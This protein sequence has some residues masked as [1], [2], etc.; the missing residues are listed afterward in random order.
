MKP[1][2]L[3]FQ[4]SKPQSMKLMKAFMPLKLKIKNVHTEDI[5]T[6]IGT[7]AGIKDMKTL[8]STEESQELSDPMIVFAGLS[9]THL[10]LALAAVRKSGVGP[11]PYKAVLTPSNQSWTAHELLEELKIEHEKMHQS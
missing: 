8:D 4:F 11:V 2:I 3:L 9:N 6:P 7:L 1:T 10:D 5:L